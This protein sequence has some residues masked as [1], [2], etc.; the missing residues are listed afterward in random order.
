MTEQHQIS[1][2]L[3]TLITQLEQIGFTIDVYQ[4]IQ[5]QKVLETFCTEIFK[6]NNENSENK[7][8][9]NFEKLKFTLSPIFCHSSV[10]QSKFY[11]VFNLYEQQLSEPIKEDKPEPKPIIK[12]YLRDVISLAFISFFLVIIYFIVFPPP[13]PP[14]FLSLDIKTINDI[15]NYKDLDTVKFR[16]NNFNIFQKNYNIIVNFG[17]TDSTTTIKDSIFHHIY[18]DTGKYEVLLKAIPK[19]SKDSIITKKLFISI[20]NLDNVPDSLSKIQI[21][22]KNL[23]YDKT[24]NSSKQEVKVIVNIYIIIS[25]IFLG[26]LIEIVFYAYKKRLFIDK[27]SPNE[28]PPYVL[29]L[30]IQEK[31]IH[32]E[33]LFFDLSKQLRQRREGETYMLNISQ[34]IDSTIRS[35][36]L[37][38]MIFEQVSKPAEYLV[39]IEQE[40]SNNQQAKFFELLVRTLIDDNVYIEFFWFSDTP[41]SL[42]N[43]IYPNGISFE[44]LTQ[45]Y[46]NHRLLIFSTGH[47]FI[48]P[49][50]KKI[51]PALKKKLDNWSE[52]VLFSP[53]PPNK[54]GAEENILNDC[55][56]VLPAD[57]EGQLFLLN[58]WQEAD[59]L[60][61]NQVRKHLGEQLGKDLFTRKYYKFENISELKSYI[62]DNTKPKFFEPVWDWLLALAVYPIPNW[63]VTLCIGKAMEQFYLNLPEKKNQYFVNLENL[64]VLTKIPWLNTLEEIPNDLRQAMLSELGQTKEKTARQAIL[65]LLEETSE[66]LPSNSM[67]YEENQQYLFTQ[68]AL[69]NVK[70]KNTWQ[71]LRKL[72]HQGQIQDKLLLPLLE[73][74]Y[75]FKP[76]FPIFRLLFFLLISFLLIWGISISP[77]TILNK[78]GGVKT[79]LLDSS[80]YYNNFGVKVYQKDTNSAKIA[81]ENALKIRPNYQI[82]RLNLKYLDFN[83]GFDFYNKEDYENT[84]KHFKS[85][86]NDDSLALT[87]NYVLALSHYYSDD[88][89][90]ARIY[91]NKLKEPFKTYILNLLNEEKEIRKGVIPNWV[92]I[93]A[94]DKT[95]QDIQPDI[96]KA[97]KA[98][99]RYQDTYIFKRVALQTGNTYFNLMLGGFNNKEEAQKFLPDV[100]RKFS[101]SAYVF[102]LNIWCDN[103]VLSKE[104]FYECQNNF[105]NP[106]KI[107]ERILP[108][109]TAPILKLEADMVLVGD[110]VFEMGCN[111]KNCEEDEKPVHRVILSNFYI[112]R[113]EV[114]QTQWK[115]IM[116]SN[117]SQANKDCDNCP[118][119]SITWEDTQA[120]LQKLNKLTGK[121][122]RLPT[123][124]EWEYAAKGGINQDNFIYS[125]SN[126]PDVVAVYNEK[127]PQKVGSKKPNSLGIYDMSGNVMEWC[128]DWYDPQFY[129]K[130]E[131]IKENPCNRV[132]G[133]S[134]NR[135]Q[136]GGSWNNNDSFCTVTKRLKWDYPKQ[137]RISS[138]FRLCLSK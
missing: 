29:E 108:K 52:K 1:F 64:F 112:G 24:L 75:A 21:E 107:T 57:L 4:R 31:T 41:Q 47:Q 58:A 101:N 12:N 25:F 134:R 49:F 77:P 43:E 93:M 103:F 72:W 14:P 61:M 6:L 27:I 94:A 68:K 10:Q 76:V 116:G 117:P 113:Y 51:F 56:T 130:P 19:Q 99:E 39:L 37:P 5:A 55:L 46:S 120:F 124:A 40:S 87:A 17:D 80:V 66:K 85:Y 127:T 125:G 48:H 138:G 74:K 100:H 98:G 8:I 59:V 45:I 63:S 90:G 67:A 121:K 109:V 96:E 71:Q 53:N 129:T 132:K 32:F 60:E 123:E 126:S 33:R 54:W 97:K 65:K 114:T 44:N 35:G 38:K 22:A 18:S 119:E 20:F 136:R 73:K 26:L 86:E 111:E 83:K 50:Y 110:G 62:E 81:F 122:Y 105:E 42:W 84:I 128:E 2:P 133:N 92:I 135:V 36:G 82:A 131:A 104:G 78:I 115:L 69:L 13:P 89:V 34:T 88:E 9:I 118:V 106:I 102:D 91:A 70:D 95:F 11:E 15:T 7:I 137:R 28:N 16:V 3:E 79:S 30:P 23:I